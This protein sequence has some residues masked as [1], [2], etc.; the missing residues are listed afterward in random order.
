MK[1]RKKIK[2]KGSFV[3]RRDRDGF[4]LGE[5]MTDEQWQDFTTNL[6]FWIE[7][8]MDEGIDTIIRDIKEWHTKDWRDKDD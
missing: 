7:S 6:Q 8:I 5:P 1:A 4:T 3:V 2:A